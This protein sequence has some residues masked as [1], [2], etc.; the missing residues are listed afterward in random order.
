MSPSYR[1]IKQQKTFY[2]SG[3]FRVKAEQL[4]KTK[5]TKTKNRA[6]KPFGRLAFQEGKRYTV[7]CRL[8]DEVRVL[9]DLPV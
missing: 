4:R 3:V 5:K 1:T 2:A 6:G 8:R 7:F 9:C